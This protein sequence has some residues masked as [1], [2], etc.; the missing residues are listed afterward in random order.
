LLLAE[1][2]AAVRAVVL[3]LFPLLARPTRAVAAVV[4]AAWEDMPLP[5]AALV[6]SLFPYQQPVTVA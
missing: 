4:V 1:L 3:L 2:V 5:Q 6:W